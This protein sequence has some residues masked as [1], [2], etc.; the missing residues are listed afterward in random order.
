MLGKELPSG[1]S[2]RRRAAAANSR[3]SEQ[4]GWP[5]MQVGWPTG[6]LQARASRWD[7]LDSRRASRIWESSNNGQPQAAGDAVFG[8]R[9]L[10]SR[11][12]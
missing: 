1:C 9:R 4:V 3:S 5:E 11:R 2:A 10:D 12:D 8:R 7:G 6:G